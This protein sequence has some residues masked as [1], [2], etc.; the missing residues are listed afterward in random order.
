MGPPFLPLRRIDTWQLI[1]NRLTTIVTILLVALLQNTQ[2]GADQAIQRK[3]NAIAEGLSNVMSQLA[4]EHPELLGDCDELRQ[5]VGLEKREAYRRDETL[6]GAPQPNRHTDGRGF[7]SRSS[8]GHGRPRGRTDCPRL[9]M[10]H[11]ER[12]GLRG[13]CATV[14]RDPV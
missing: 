2:K 14:L 7:V 12:H 1:I 4:G 13:L 11:L 8:S 10:A 6:R 9:R 3:L 5:A